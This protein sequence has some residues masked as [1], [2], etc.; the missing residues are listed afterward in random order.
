[1]IKFK[2]WL[3]KIPSVKEVPFLPYWDGSFS[4]SRS[5]KPTSEIPFLPHWDGSFASIRQKIANKLRGQVDE[6][7]KATVPFMGVSYQPPKLPN[8]RPWKDLTKTESAWS[9]QAGK[10]VRNKYGGSHSKIHLHPDYK[11][12]SVNE[13][14]R[15]ALEGYTM[16]DSGSIN[17]HLRET[18]KGSK[19]GMSWRKSAHK[20]AK[21]LYSLFTPENTNK[22]ELHTY[23]GVPH[24]GIGEHLLTMKP[25]D[26]SHTP[27]FMS[28]SHDPS[29]ARLF[30]SGHYDYDNDNEYGSNPRH[31][32]HWIHSKPKHSKVPGTAISAG[33]DSEHDEE[34]FIT[35]P[36]AH[37]TYEGV[38][39]HI[40]PGTG[41]VYHVHRI[42]LDPH[43]G[44]PLEEFPGYKAFEK[45]GAKKPAAKKK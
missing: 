6:A 15:E 43:R 9:K 2:D 37:A 5:K 38:T 18:A 40:E 22:Q 31:I 23:S 4:G 16:G 25:G 17:S 34:E 12:N 21:H 30:A 45:G 19:T 42:R 39:S 24:E 20:Q 10:K 13:D 41:H 3:R 27:N 29:I 1:M 7:A 8:E 32:I 28:S 33:A 26:E 14:Q 35:A 11:L 36:G 44:K